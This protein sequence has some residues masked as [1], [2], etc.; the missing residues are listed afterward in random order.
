MVQHKRKWRILPQLVVL[1]VLLLTTLLSLHALADE[2]RTKSTENAQVDALVETLQKELLS[3]KYDRARLILIAARQGNAKACNTMG[4]MFDNGIV[5]KQDSTKALQW[6][7]SCAKAN[8]YAS[9]NAAVLLYAGRGT[10]EDKKAAIPYYR[11]AWDLGLHFHQI[12]LRLAYFYHKDMSFADAWVW[13]EKAGGELNEP[14][15]KCLQASMLLEGSAPYKDDSK[16]VDL[17]NLALASSSTHAAELL[18]WVYGSGRLGEKN[19]N[20]SYKYALVAAKT[21][22]KLQSMATTWEKSL[23][24]EEKKAAGRYADKWASSHGNHVELDFTS[25]YLSGNHAGK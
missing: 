5:V 8:P 15:G 16:A 24:E 25:T 20:L 2:V 23:T 14:D 11:T 6:F 13:A 17:L 10:K 1:A 19:P 3:K 4:W 9:Y 18:A 7:R 12:P 22:P 21:S